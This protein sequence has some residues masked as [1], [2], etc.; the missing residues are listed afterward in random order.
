MTIKRKQGL[1]IYPSKDMIDD[2]N[3]KAKQEDRST[4]NFILRIL[5]KYLYKQNERSTKK[6]S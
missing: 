5:K 3:N 6:Q 2:I 4:S 1:T